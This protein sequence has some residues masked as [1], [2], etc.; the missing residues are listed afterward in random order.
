MVNT[1][2]LT[3]LVT[4]GAGFIGSHLIE[5]LLDRGMRILIIDNLSTGK[6]ENIAHLLKGNYDIK[7]YKAPITNKVLLKKLIKESDIIY[8]LAAAV[9]VKYIL[10]HPV[11]SIITNVEGTSLILHL[12]ATYKKK[13][14]L[15]S[16]SEVYGK[17]VC[18]PIKEEDDR[19][20]GSTSI[21]RWSYSDSKAIDEFLALAYAK[22][23]NLPIV[24]VRL[25][26]TV[27]PRQVGHYGMVLPRF[28]ERAL[29]NKPIPVY[30]DGS[31]IRT[32]TYV[33][34]AV[35]AIADLSLSPKAVGQAFNIGS[36][37][38]I[39]IMELAKKVK[40][41]TNSKSQIKIIPYKKAYG[42]DFEDIECRIPDI[43]KIKKTIKYSPQYDIDSIIENTIDYFKG[44]IL[45]K[46]RR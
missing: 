26:N 11:D 42:K 3:A 38:P 40:E 24:I 45:Q 5:E 46:K 15:A 12:A 35:R 4:G 25:F 32:F 8:H 18:S 10:D 7:F 34:D 22:E 2:K 1:K 31:Q 20:L 29:L 33:K 28:I 9:G 30:G 16:T 14:V 27:G 37:Q 41:K 13:V 23:K 39:T 36:N 21:S 43:S 44:K 17:H 19:T 6:K